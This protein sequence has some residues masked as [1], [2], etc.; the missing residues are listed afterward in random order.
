M[1]G[2]HRNSLGKSIQSYTKY[3]YHNSEPSNK[4][5]LSKSLYIN[6]AASNEESIKG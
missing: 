2:N 4:R 5:E 6:R 3:V 1:I